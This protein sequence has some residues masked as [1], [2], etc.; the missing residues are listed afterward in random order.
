MDPL[1]PDVTDGSGLNV[2]PRKSHFISQALG[3]LARGLR[4]LSKTERT[5]WLLVVL[6]A[7]VL[8]AYLRPNVFVDDAAITFRYVERLT[9]GYGFNYNEHE[10]VLGTSAPLYALAL[11]AFVL[12]GARVETAAMVLSF[13]CFIRNRRSNDVSY[14]A[15][16]G[17]QT[18]RDCSRGAAFSRRFLSLPVSVR[19]GVRNG[20]VPRTLDDR[21]S[22]TRSGELSGSHPRPRSMEQARRRLSW[23][24]R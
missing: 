7:T 17:V 14:S 9:S 18:R 20:R 21:S 24:W 5:D 12:L 6:G 11:S 1:K 13:I 19:H 16:V 15:I 2:P 22:S 23:L 8:A 3:G 10:N 4:A